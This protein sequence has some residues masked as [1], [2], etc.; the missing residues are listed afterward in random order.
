MKICKDCIHYNI[1][2]YSTIAD[3]EVNCKDFIS[4][5]IKVDTV[6]KFAKYLK[7]YSFMCDPGN[8]HSFYAIDID[9]LDD[10]VKEFLE[11]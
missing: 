9:E 8:G 5:T 10:Y 11:D 3:K 6:Q 7:E 1:C 4:K 2:E